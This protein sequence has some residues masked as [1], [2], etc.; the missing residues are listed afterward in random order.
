M[1]TTVFS[2]LLNKPIHKILC[3]WCGTPI[4]HGGSCREA[5]GKICQQEEDYLYEQEWLE[6]QYRREYEEEEERKRW[7]QFAYQ[8]RLREE[9]FI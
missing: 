4:T 1:Y 5:T 8:E 2:N 7:E 3:G 9:G 6:E